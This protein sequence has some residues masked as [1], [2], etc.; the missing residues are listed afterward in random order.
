M[1]KYK[2]KSEV[3]QTITADGDIRPRVIKAG[4]ELISSRPIE[5]PNLEF[6]GEADAPDDAKI[7]A[8][9]DKTNVTTDA[10]P[11]TP[12]TENEESN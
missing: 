12:N 7:V 2:N 6:I 10:Q 4:G 8:V 1:Y 3:T 11:A 9:A 5:N